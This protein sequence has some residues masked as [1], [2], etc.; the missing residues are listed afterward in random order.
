MSLRIIGLTLLLF[1][2][3]VEASKLPELTPRDT[4]IKIQEILKAHVNHHVLTTEIIE[5]SFHNYL[6]QLDPAKIYFVEN[7]VI[8]WE[9]P[10]QELLKEAV[11]NVKKGNFS[12]FEELHSILQPAIQRRRLIEEISLQAS[13]EKKYKADDFRDLEW[14]KSED[15]LTQRILSL[16]AL[17]LDAAE[18]L[19][20][21]RKELFMQKIEKRRVKREEELI[22][23]SSK[24][25]KKVIL[26]LVLKSL[27]GALDSQTVYF[28]PAEASQFMIQVQQR[29]FGIGAQLR[30]DLN[31][32]T[33]V[34]LLEGGPAKES[35]QLRA[36]DRIIAVNDEPVVGM[37]IIEAVELI[38]GPKGTPVNLTILREH[39]EVLGNHEEKL[40]IEIIRGE[41]ILKETRMEKTYEP[42]GDGVI[43]ILHLFSFYQDSHTSSAE[44]IHEAILELQREH[45]LKGIILDLRDNSG[46]LLPQAVA[47]TGLFIKKGVVVS[48][49]DNTGM[50]QHLRNISGKMVWGGPLAV[51]TDITSASAAEIVAQTLQ[52]YGRAVLI[53]DERTFGKGTYQTFTLESANYGKV[54][55][56]GEYK[57]TRGCYYTVSGKSPQLVGV[58]PD[59]IVPGIYSGLKI[60]EMYTKYPLE[61][62][63]IK[64]S[65]IDDL[66]DVP[67]IHRKQIERLYKFNLQPIL[68]TYEPYIE[69]LKRNSMLRIEQNKN[70]QNFLKAISDTKD[71][72]S[73]E[74]ESFGI[75][76]LQYIEAT[77][78][79][80]DLLLLMQENGELEPDY[81]QAAGG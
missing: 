81:Q 8:K 29:L 24:N 56:K 70:Y 58:K 45:N 51:L 23:T 74:M 28:T 21:D 68:T 80:K 77:N 71:E 27:T 19:N 66:A 11:E 25:Q 60:G 31:G 1:F 52:D 5:R 9:E 75:S 38:R 49:K 6:G 14:S 41:V 62:D 2:T 59:I 15:E 10:S 46:G 42:F 65:F 43:G 54:N 20:P 30:D 7:E 34:R 79:M 26:S 33:I 35:N 64:P 32:F 3:Q 73:E 16:R 78:I 53:G 63:R 44:D 57:V 55:S 61:N 39:D 13:M 69:T 36:N 17:Q 12:N 48:I 40:E 50:V 76:D 72:I 37:E 67:P 18:K 47:V 4:K 22:A